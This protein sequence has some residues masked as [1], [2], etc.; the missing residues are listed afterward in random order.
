MGPP[1]HL[2]QYRKHHSHPPLNGHAETPPPPTAHGSRFNRDIPGKPQATD[3]HHSSGAVWESRW[4]SWAVRPNEPSGFR[5]RKEL[6]NRASALVTTCPYYVNWHLRTL[7]INSPS[8][9]DTALSYTNTIP[10]PIYTNTIPPPVYTN[11]IPPPIYTNTIPPPIYKNTIP[12]PVQ[13]HKY[14]ASSCLHKYHTPSYSH[15]CST[16]FYLRKYN[17]PSYLHWQIPCPLLFTQ[18]PYA[19]LSQRN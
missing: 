2:D 10:P 12:H 19:L 8:A 16:C 3:T 13:L 1:P 11:T 4:T 15:K 7:S 5:G 17:S 18:I 14:H 9:T 6:L